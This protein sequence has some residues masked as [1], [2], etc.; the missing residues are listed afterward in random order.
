MGCTHA[1]QIL[2]KRK[3]AR[4]SVTIVL[5]NKII[6]EM[7]PV[8]GDGGWGG[9]GVYTVNHEVRHTRETRKSS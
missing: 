2:P 9:G 5:L 1:S 3:A 8:T 4:P 7:S 6:V